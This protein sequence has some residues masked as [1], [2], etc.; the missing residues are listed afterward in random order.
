M[1]YKTGDLICIKSG[2]NKH[3]VVRVDN[4][5]DFPEID[6]LIFDDEDI[7][8]VRRSD[9]KFEVIKQ[10]LDYYAYY[11]IDKEGK[12]TYIDDKNLKIGKNDTTKD[13][14]AKF[15]NNVTKVG[16]VHIL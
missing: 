9:I 1:K 13:L 12:R 15:E 14:I 8:K 6:F 5:K 4:T 10:G 2:I 3:S 11:Y 16:K 7:K